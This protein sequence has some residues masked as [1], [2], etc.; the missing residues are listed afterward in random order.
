M[1]SIIYFHPI[2]QAEITHINGTRCGT[3]GTEKLIQASQTASRYHTNGSGVL[4]LFTVVVG[5]AHQEALKAQ[6]YHHVSV[7][8]ICGSEGGKKTETVYAAV[9]QSLE[10]DEFRMMRNRDR[11][12]KTVAHTLIFSILNSKPV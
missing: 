2:F 1:D 10:K 4:T 7:Q 9:D 11:G 5:S 8:K 12:K 3:N 6:H